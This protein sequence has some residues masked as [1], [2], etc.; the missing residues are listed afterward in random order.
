MPA[1]TDTSTKTSNWLLR[2]SIRQSEDSIRQQVGALLD[3]LSIEY[4]LSY[5]SPYALEPCDIYLPRRRTIIATKSTGGAE[6]P[7]RLESDLSNESPK[8]RL[9]RYLRAEIE[10][11]LSSSGSEEKDERPW[12]GVLT[13]GAI[14]HAWR[15]PHQSNTVGVQ[16]GTAF[17]TSDNFAS[18]NH[19]RRLV[20]DNLVGKPWIPQNPRPIFESRL[21]DLSQIYEALP[22]RARQSTATKHAQWLEMLRASGIEPEND[23]ESLKLFVKHSFLVALARAVI[24]VLANPRQVPDVD[25][26]LGNG[27]VAWVIETESGR[28]WASELFREVHA[29]EWRRRPGDV[30]RPLYEEFVGTSDRKVYGEFYTPDWLAQMLVRE[31]CDEDWCTHAVERALIAYK[32]NTTFEG[33]GVLD[34]TCGSGTFLYH[35]ALRLLS[36]PNILSLSNTDKS[37]VVC[38][39]VNGFDIHPVAAEIAR[40]TLLRALPAEPP[41]G[42][43]ALRIHEGDALLLYGDDETS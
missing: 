21:Q 13:D 12:L 2:N 23:L 1:A 25:K 6:D 9:E 35:A 22:S 8:Q 33:T 15:Y 42:E 39:L 19:L 5:R 26:V 14:W 7:Y 17:R 3:S 31:V 20:S 36:S 24:Q 32:N 16:V 4:E 10:Y 30:L 11:E 40:A 28:Q 43:S 27:F 41:Q 34:P 18:I 29:Y 38:M 37:A